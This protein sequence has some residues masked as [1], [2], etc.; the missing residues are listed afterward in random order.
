MGYSNSKSVSTY[1]FGIPTNIYSV[2]GSIKVTQSQVGREE[3]SACA[4]CMAG[5][6][7]APRV[8]SLTQCL[9]LVPSICQALQLLFMMVLMTQHHATGLFA[10][11]FCTP[12]YP[13]CLLPPASFV[14]HYR[15]HCLLCRLRQAMHVIP[16]FKNSE[17]IILL[18]QNFLNSKIKKAMVTNKIKTTIHYLAWRHLTNSSWALKFSRNLSNIY[19]Q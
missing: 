14:S 17:V 7:K 6:A 16:F 19:F 4:R 18:S 12:S 10:D 9:E 3:R 8:A 13:R 5:E 2:H 1:A 15:R 11:L